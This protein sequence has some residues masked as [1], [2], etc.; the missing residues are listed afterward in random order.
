M[1]IAY[2]FKNLPPTEAIKTYATK[3]IDKLKERL[4]HIEGI[5]VRFSLE[6]QNQFF[7]ITVHG[8]ATVF[9]LKKSDKDLYAAIDNALDVLN[10]QID[11]YRKKFEEKSSSAREM[12]LPTSGERPQEDE[13]EITVR[14][15]EVKPMDDL[16]AVLQLRSKKFRFLMYHHADERNYGL[17]TARNDGNYSIVMPSK[18]GGGFLETVARF[19]EDKLEKLSEAIY[20][21]SKFT[22]AEALD[23]LN[24][25]NLE[26]LAFENEDTGKLNVIFHAQGS[27]LMI[28]RPST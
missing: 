7:E 4:H 26:Y 8:D 14:D 19:Q 9:H 15:A 3:K 17:A 2:Y 25:A 5:D 28:K 27:G 21:V 6:R 10:N 22:V 11:K 1:E 13:T 16:E 20:P 23:M 12:F 18:G 24:E